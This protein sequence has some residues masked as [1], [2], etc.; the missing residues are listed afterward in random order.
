MPLRPTRL[1][2][3]WRPLALF[4]ALLAG[5]AHPPQAPDWIRNPDKGYPADRYT[6][7][8]GAGADAERAANNARAQIVRA[9]QG[10]TEGIEIAETWIDPEPQTHW[11]LA[12][13]DR[14]AL[15]A[16]LQEELSA[17]ESQRNEV[18]S[19][20][21]GGPPERALSAV[22]QALDLTASI[23][24]I[25]VRIAHLE[26]QKAESPPEASKR[27]AFEARLAEIKRSLPIEIEA[28]EMDP[29][30]GDPGDPLDELRR[31]LAQQVIALGFPVAETGGWGVAES[32]WLVA[33]ARVATERLQ[34]LKRDRLVAV[35][36]D[37][38]LEIIDLTADGQLVAVLTDEGRATHLNEVEA[39]RQAREE[40]EQFLSRALG[41]WLRLRITPR[42]Q[43]T[44]VEPRSP[45]GAAKASATSASTSLPVSDSRK[46][47]T[48]STSRSESP[49]GW[50]R[51]SSPS[52]GTPP[53][54]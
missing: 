17:L 10:E 6:V 37:A 31:A 15:V 54:S 45:M 49:S 1:F 14:Q 19:A 51:G 53:R 9:T 38:A 32:T 50:I 21:E 8:L 18:M 24:S 3:S 20:A 11:A 48:S 16:R 46:A 27:A 25:G 33:R 40:A 42:S 12:V 23:D 34:L 26:G 47:T 2:H 41:D 43:R 7:G 13:L 36:W 4:T 5:C 35:H 22:V 28:N 39:T 52:F 29:K 30:T 44:G